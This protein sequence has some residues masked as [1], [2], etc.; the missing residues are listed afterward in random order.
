MKAADQETFELKE[1][2]AIDNMEPVISWT[3]MENFS[4]S[5]ETEEAMYGLIVG[6]VTTYFLQH[7]G[8]I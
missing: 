5:N 6:E 7:Q 4:S 2:L 3:R 1:Y 8:K